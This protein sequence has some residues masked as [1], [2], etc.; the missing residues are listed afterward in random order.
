MKQASPEEPERVLLIRTSARHVA[1]ISPGEAGKGWIPLLGTMLDAVAPHLSTADGAPA[2]TARVRLFAMRPEDLKAWDTLRRHGSDG[3][4]LGSLWGKKS[5]VK[6]VQ[7]KEVPL[8]A[9]GAGVRPPIDPVAI[10]T[11]VAGAQ[12]RAEVQQL[13]DLVERVAFNVE[14][15]LDFLH[16][17]Q[18]A[19]ILAAIETIDQIYA[20]YRDELGIT[21]IDWD[22]LAGLEQVLKSQHRRIIGELDKVAEMLRFT[23]FAEAKAAAHIDTER[24]EKLIHLEWYL[25]CALNKWGEMV[26]AAKAGRGENSVAAAE[27][28]RR[29]REDYLQDARAVLHKIKRADSD[30]AGRSLLKRLFTQ[31]L[32]LGWWRDND[33]KRAAV[34]RRTAVCQLPA[35]RRRLPAPFAAKRVRL[36]FDPAP[37]PTAAAPAAV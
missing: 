13:A 1:A 15:I 31:G 10:A 11:A 12:I 6:N 32:P 19:D 5:I 36:Q 3:Y 25:L 33:V 4:C 21:S 26:L 28:I 9:Q 7:I 34:A 22:R 23:E 18:E 17:G 16:L 14:A 30:M 35:V 2:Q 29:L 20:R 8:S 37:P 27:E 24:V